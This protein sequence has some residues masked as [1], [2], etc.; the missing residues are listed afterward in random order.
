VVPWTEMQNEGDE[1]QNEGD[2]MQNWWLAGI[3]M[4]MLPT[5]SFHHQL[6][7]S[8]LQAKKMLC[9]ICLGQ[10]VSA[11]CISICCESLDLQW[12]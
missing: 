7:D 8:C 6:L 4:V 3:C 5:L 10:T 9:R 2:E 12:I 1:M 11:A